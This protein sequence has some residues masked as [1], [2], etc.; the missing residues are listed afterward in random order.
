MR[1]TCRDKT[2][3]KPKCHSERIFPRFCTEAAHAPGDL[4]TAGTGALRQP[5]IRVFSFLRKQKAKFQKIRKN[6]L[7]LSL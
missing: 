3:K 7:S 6:E 4:A 5:A 2:R 1:R